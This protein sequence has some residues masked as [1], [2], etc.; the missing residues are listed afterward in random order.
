MSLFKSIIE[1]IILQDTKTN[2]KSASL[3]TTDEEIQALHTIRTILIQNKKISNDRITCRDVKGKFNIL[4]DDNPRK[5]ICQLK[6]TD[7]S[8]KITIGMNDYLLDSIDNLSKFKHELNVRA[9]SF[10]E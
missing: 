9:L 8:K 2:S 3:I 6:F 1:I 7:S 5:T 10:L 4:V